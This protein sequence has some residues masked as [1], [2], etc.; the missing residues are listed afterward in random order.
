MKKILRSLI[1]IFLITG[2]VSL[3]VVIIGL[4][5]RWPT[6]IHF[7]DGFFWAGVII[8]SIGA[9]IS[10]GDRDV[11]LNPSRKIQPQTPQDEF[12]ALAGAGD[13]PVD[14]SNPLTDSGS[15]FRYDVLLLTSAGLL[16]LIGY[17]ITL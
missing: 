3:I 14:T 1:K 4:I 15:T 13:P 12:A 16:I 5:A 2:S 11:R 9:L 7:S 6:I 8:G 10:L 17:L